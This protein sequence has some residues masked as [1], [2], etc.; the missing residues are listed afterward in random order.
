[1]TRQRASAQPGPHAISIKAIVT[2]KRHAAAVDVVKGECFDRHRL[3][4]Q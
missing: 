2:A 3:N 1:M 4:L